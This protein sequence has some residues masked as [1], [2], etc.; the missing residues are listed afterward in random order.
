MTASS[1]PQKSP[2]GLGVRPLLHWHDT[3][4]FF[5][6]DREAQIIRSVQEGNSPE[7][8]W[9]PGAEPPP[10][11]LAGRWREVAGLPINQQALFASMRPQP[12][13]FFSTFE[14]SRQV[15]ASEFSFSAH[16]L[17]RLVFHLARGA[18]RLRARVWFNPGAYNPPPGNT[19]TDGVEVRLS[20]LT[21]GAEPRLLATRLVDPT[22][23]PTDRGPVPIEFPV[24]LEQDGELELWFG[25]GP[26]G[27]D[28]R[29]WIWIRGP[30][31]ID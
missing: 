12:V 3:W 23:I 11:L 20:E 16:P 6:K 27:R 28:T 22:S 7:M 19:A 9:A 15:I 14:P 25:P 13:R 29:D 10:E 2:V 30:L 24:T 5:R 26:Q 8:N 31:V 4:L 17:T 18:H 21:M 1:A